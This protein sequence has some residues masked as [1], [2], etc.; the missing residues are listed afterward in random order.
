MKLAVIIFCVIVWSGL[1]RT[2]DATE[3]DDIL[4]RDVFISGQDGYHTYRIPAMVITAKGSVLAFCEGRKE[5]RG[6]SGNIDIL[7]TL[8]Y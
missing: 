5:G 4:R 7:L 3:K 8:A 6:D 2:I 1:T